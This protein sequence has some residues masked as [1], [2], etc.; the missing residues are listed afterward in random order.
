MIGFGVMEWADRYSKHGEDDVAQRNYFQS[1][2]ETAR[3]LLARGYKIRLLIGDFWDVR[4]KQTFLQFLGN[5]DSRLV[6][7]EPIRSVDDLMSQIEAT[8]AVVA[9]RFHNILLSLFREKPVIS[10]SFHHKCDSLMAAMGL[11]D[12][13]INSGDL[14]ADKLIETF[15]RLER[16]ADVLKSLIIEKNNGFRDALDEQY[17]LVL[18]AI[19]HIRRPAVTTEILVNSAQRVDR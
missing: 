13:C 10:I 4:P 11:S 2:A 3:W 19:R 18:D 1:L 5:H 6:I 8:D 7:D 14:E 12:Y 9:T 16:N 15:C 17:Q